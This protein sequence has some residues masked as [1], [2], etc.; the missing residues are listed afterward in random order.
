MHFSFVE[1]FGAS[2]LITMWLV[3]G[4]IMIG[5]QAVRPNEA[6]LEALRIPTPEDQAAPAQAAAAAGPDT[7]MTLLAS[8]NPEAGQKAFKKCTACHT[9]EKGGPN[10]VGP[11]LWN[12]V[13]RKKGS[14]PGFSYSAA[15]ANLGSEWTYEDMNKFITNPR[16]FAPGNKMTF[17][18]VPSSEERAAII[19]YLR[20]LSDSPKP[21]P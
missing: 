6:G 5:N 7:T 18:G 20:T 8:A 3:W 19:A 12:V 16:A 9:A 1:K 4:S 15:V 2:V 21:L 14:T 13:G 10:R 17:P 11:N